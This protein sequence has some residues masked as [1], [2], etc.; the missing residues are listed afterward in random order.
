M[1]RALVIAAALAAAFSF[2][3]AA[4]A[5]FAHAF[6]DRALPA[7][8][9]TVHGPPAEVKLW[10]TQALEPAFSTVRVLDAAGRQVD[11]RDKRVDRDDATLLRVSLPP[12]ASGTYRVVWRVLSRDAH[13]TQGDYRFEVAP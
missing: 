12:L 7:V 4:G 13:A 8:G 2:L 9:S 1:R 6:I 11:R 5:A 3:F 10:F